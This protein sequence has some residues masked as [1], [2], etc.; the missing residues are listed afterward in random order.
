MLTEQHPA[1]AGI[2]F[3]GWDPGL[4]EGPFKV[5]TIRFGIHSCPFGNYLLGISGEDWVVS[6]EF[7]DDAKTM[8]TS[9]GNHWNHSTL[10]HDPESTAGVAARLFAPVL[11]TP[12]DLL[13]RGTPFQLRVWEALLHIPFG[14]TVT[15]QQIATSV[16][17]P[18]ALQAVGSA[19]GK[20][21]IAWLIPCHRVIRKSGEIT[22]FRWGTRRKAAMLEWERNVR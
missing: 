19:I 6:L 12:V 10:V 18:G 4:H 13:A 7:V 2:T 16:G 21:P 3:H 14:N 11:P 15:Y 17:K 1:T 5:D 20:N 22:R 9:L 8:I